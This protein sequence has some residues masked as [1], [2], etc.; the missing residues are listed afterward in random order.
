[1]QKNGGDVPPEKKTY[2]PAAFSAIYRPDAKFGRFLSALVLSGVAY[3]LYR[4]I[5]DNYLAEIVHITAFERGIVE[6]FRE[7]P[8]L[9]VIFILAVLYRFSESRIFKIGICIMA[10]GL[11]GFFLSGTGKIIVVMNMV[12][13]SFGEHIIMPVRSTI[14]LDLAKRD[15]GGASLGITTAISNVGNIAGF[16]VVTALFF[17]FSRLG[18]ARTDLLRFKSVFALSG[19]LMLGAVLTVLALRESHTKA[20]RRRLYFSK[21][22]YKFYM[23]EIFYGARKQVFFTFAPYVLILHYG[24]DTSIISM[25][26]AVCAVFGFVLSPLMG[27]LIDRL[28][29]KIIMVTDTLILIVVC[30]L[31]GFAHRLF[32]ARIAFIVVCINYILD[33]VISLASMASNIYVQDIASD[34]EEI[35]ATLSTGVSVNH[36]ISIAIALMGGWLWKIAGIEVLFSMSAILG[37]INSLYAATIKNPKKL[38]DAQTLKK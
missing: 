14:S 37:L 4:G 5:Q 16:V 24:A 19:V 28:G 31:Y 32:P 38:P 29:Y 30:L 36:I 13:F 33:S 15:Q 2:I 10:A 20:K 27:R 6:F 17:I 21:K 26:L 35:T 7:I 34:S 8:G 9:L 18:F 25:L 22:F 23:L 1:M 12:L 3:G 11:V